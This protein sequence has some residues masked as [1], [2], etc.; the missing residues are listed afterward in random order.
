MQI[1]IVC[2]CAF[3]FVLHDDPMFLQPVELIPATTTLNNI[4]GTC[5]TVDI[6]GFGKIRMDFVNMFFSFFFQFV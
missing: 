3:L 1:F 2:T 5:A 6:D 4:Y